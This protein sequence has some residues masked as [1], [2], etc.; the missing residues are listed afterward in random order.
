MKE[1][2]LAII[3]ARGGSKRIPRKNIKA[4]LGKPIISYSIEAALSSE[5]FNEV[6]VS[7]D[8]EEIKEVAIRYGA[9][10]PFLR[11]T[12]NSDDFATT[13]DVVREVV[14]EYRKLGKN[15]TIGCCLY[16]AAPFITS[17][18]LCEAYSLLTLNHYDSVFPVLRYGAPIQRSLKVGPNK[19]ITMCF[20]EFIH[21]R[22]QDLEP[23][24]HDAGQFYWMNIPT[25]L[26]KQKI[27][28]DNSGGIEI[29]EREGQD[30][31][32]LDDWILAELKYTLLQSS[33]T[34]EK[35]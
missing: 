35:L 15:F 24:F 16:P 11:S 27:W 25:V 10:V 21:S 14:T 3:P 6:M 20:P 33:K 22:S 30:I 2:R 23:T 17:K 34:D 1:N 28:T 8:D 32:T 5:L 7:T 18:N 12:K 4:F 13:L 31:D 29:R 9:K 26:E 19:R